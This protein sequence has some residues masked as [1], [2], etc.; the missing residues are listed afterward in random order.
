MQVSVRAVVRTVV[1][2]AAMVVESVVQAGVL[3]VLR[4]RGRH[5]PMIVPFIGH[6]STHRV[7]LAGR[8]VLGRPAAA[9]PADGVP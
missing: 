9:A 6:G 7:R 2:R 3:L 1:V 5:L 4:A 8:V